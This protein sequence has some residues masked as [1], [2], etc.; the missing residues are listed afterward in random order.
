MNASEKKEFDLTDTRDIL[1]QIYYRIC[2]YNK[3]HNSDL[4][5]KDVWIRNTEY[6]G[7]SINEIIGKAIVD[8]LENKN[9]FTNP[10]ED[11]LIVFEATPEDYEQE[12]WNAV[13]LYN[14]IYLYKNYYH[15]NLYH[16]DNDEVIILYE[17]GRIEVVTKTENGEKV[18][19]DIFDVIS[20]NVYK[21]YEQLYKKQGLNGKLSE[22]SNFVSQ[23]VS[24]IKEYNSALRL[25]K[26]MSVIFCNGFNFDSM[27]HKTSPS[28]ARKYLCPDI[29]IISQSE[30][31]LKHAILPTDRND[32]EFYGYFPVL[33]WSGK[34]FSLYL[35]YTEFDENLE[36]WVFKPW[37]DN[38]MLANISAELK[39]ELNALFSP[40]IEP[41]T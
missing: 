23:A 39:Q 2:I 27:D 35:Q 10:T 9:E 32:E 25:D 24:D 18:F 15:E 29:E 13:I 16:D 34:N 33:T 36:Q 4:G 6:Y 20:D 38:K 31:I 12:H 3:L 7:E 26:I 40:F 41:L 11:E 22:L 14:Y 30:V 37:R 5:D 17:D 8:C 28:E 19:K 1:N 21:Y